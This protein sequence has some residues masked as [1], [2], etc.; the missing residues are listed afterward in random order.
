MGCVVETRETLKN[1][2]E[3]ERDRERE[4]KLLQTGNMMAE[5]KF[6]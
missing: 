4:R 2:R 6:Q 1:R 3:T 5:I